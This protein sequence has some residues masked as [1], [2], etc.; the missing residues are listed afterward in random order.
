MLINDC[1]PDVITLESGLLEKADTVMI[2]LSPML[3]WHR[4]VDELNRIGDVVR[5]VHIVSVRNEC[6]ELLIII[7]Q[8]SNDGK[9]NL[10]E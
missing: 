3:D 4:A 5:E 10:Y 2:K 1:T 6:K 7:K 8:K 9:Q